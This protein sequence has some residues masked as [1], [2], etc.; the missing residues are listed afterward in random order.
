VVSADQAATL[1][2]ATDAGIA[3][4]RLIAPGPA[5]ERFVAEAAS[6]PATDYAAL[7]DEDWAD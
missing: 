5:V 7:G 6:K 1:C 4:A 3:G 2:G